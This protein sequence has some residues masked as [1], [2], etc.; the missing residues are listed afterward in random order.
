MWQ[1]HLSILGKVFPIILPDSLTDI[2]LNI[3]LKELAEQMLLSSLQRV[4]EVSQ[5]VCLSVCSMH[6]HHHHCVWFQVLPDSSPLI[7]ISD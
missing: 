2:S 3:T 4:Q 7:A 6:G 1:S 5:S